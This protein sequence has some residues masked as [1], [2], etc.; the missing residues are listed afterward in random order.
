MINKETMFID[1]AIRWSKD[2]KIFDKYGM[3]PNDS[4]SVILSK[5]TT[6]FYDIVVSLQMWG[7]LVL[8]CIMQPIM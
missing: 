3:K 6:H 2:K 4:S 7:Y 8:V 5:V 1:S